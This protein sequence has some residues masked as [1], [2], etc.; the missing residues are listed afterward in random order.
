MKGS[1]Q[2]LGGHVELLRG[3]VQG[4]QAPW[5]GKNVGASERL[6]L[7]E[8]DQGSLESFAIWQPKC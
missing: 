6:G 4:G 7:F 2:C 3:L 5:A 1:A 8:R